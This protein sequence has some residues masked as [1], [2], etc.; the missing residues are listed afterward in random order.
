MAEYSLDRALPAE[1]VARSAGGLMSYRNFPVFSATWLKRRSMLFG[2]ILGLFG[3][4]TLMGM[5]MASRDFLLSLA[6]AGMAFGAFMLM[7]CAGPGMATWVRHRGWPERRER[8]GVVAALLLGVLFS[9]AID[10]TISE[11]LENQYIEPAMVK[12]GVITEEMAKN[13]PRPSLSARVTGFLFLCVIYGLLGGALA[14][15]AYFQERHRWLEAERERTLTETERRRRSA[16]LRLGVLQAQI[17]PHFLFNTLASLR[18]LVRQD[19]ARAEATIDALVDHL[20]ATI[21]KLRDG[22]DALHSTLAQ[23]FEICRSYLALMQVRMGGR[24]TFS[25]DLPAELREAA[26]PPL[27]LISLVENAIKHGIE[28]KSGPGAVR[29][30]ATRVADAAGSALQVEVADTGVGLRAAT[31]SGIGLA[32][33]RDQ[34]RERFAGRARLDIEGLAGGGTLARIVIPEAP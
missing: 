30:G 4:L 32:N 31:S 34:L 13:P 5:L 16:E 26:F 28:P 7:A 12:S 14:L 18:A 6:A 33:I 9:Y 22:V 21:P 11:R 20:R 1:V 29:V 19:P 15:R 10:I 23:Q 3:L 24:F 25:I 17:E 8:I 27:M 2:V